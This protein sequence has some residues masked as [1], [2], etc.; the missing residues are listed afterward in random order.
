MDKIIL[1]GFTKDL[2][3]KLQA[4]AKEF[5]IETI[6]T[7]DKDLKVPMEDIL[8]YKKSEPDYKNFSHAISFIFFSNMDRNKLYDFLKVANKMG[9]NLP[10]KSVATP[11][12]LRWTLEYL[13]DHIKDEHRVVTKWQKLGEYV[14]RLESDETIEIEKEVRDEIIEKAHSFKTDMNL[15]EEMIDELI[16]KIEEYLKD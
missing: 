12:N 2:N 13:M 9:I 11:N 8:Y 4:I 6:Y 10:H 5:E 3:L 7:G 14:K 16:L 15:T 1:Y